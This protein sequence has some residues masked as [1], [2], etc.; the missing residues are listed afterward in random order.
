MGIAVPLGILFIVGHTPLWELLSPAPAQR[1]WETLLTS[2]QSNFPWSQVKKISWA[3][4]T[5]LELG[6]GK[7][8][9]TF[10]CLPQ[11][12]TKLS[13]VYFYALESFCVSNIVAIKS[14]SFW[15][16]GHMW[17]SLFW[18]GVKVSRILRVW[19]S[20]WRW[21]QLFKAA[22]VQV[23]H[24]LVDS[25]SIFPCLVAVFRECCPNLWRKWKLVVGE[26]DELQWMSW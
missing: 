2:M 10:S 25:E 19:L 13:F 7:V 9:K 23:P 3:Y 20:D 15:K 24:L 26:L 4:H 21:K 8:R 5:P 14:F 12:A 18:F 6:I 17:D 11:S 1:S 16:Y 22:P